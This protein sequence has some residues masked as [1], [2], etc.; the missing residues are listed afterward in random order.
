MTT[1]QEGCQLQVAW[2]SWVLQDPVGK[3]S[4]ACSGSVVCRVNAVWAASL[5][6]W[7]C[8]DVCLSTHRKAN[9]SL[10][11]AANSR[12]QLSECAGGMHAWI[13]PEGASGIP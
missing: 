11:Q 7:R 3:F 9:D 8:S 13:W 6:N 4:G 2:P 10:G 1:A 5:H 12:C